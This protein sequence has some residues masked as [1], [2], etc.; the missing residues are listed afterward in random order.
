M[1]LE[2]STSWNAGSAR[3]GL[4]STPRSM[5]TPGTDK[6]LGDAVDLVVLDMMLPGRSGLEVLEL[7]HN[8][9]ADAAG[10]RAH[11]AR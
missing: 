11:R 9:Q 1:S 6:A 10:D 5:A 8:F 7:I 3:T 2:S 4:R